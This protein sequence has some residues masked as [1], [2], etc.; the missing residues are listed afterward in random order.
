MS[1]SPVG[2]PRARRPRFSRFGL[3]L[4]AA[5]AGSLAL[6][7][8]M[9]T[10][11]AAF[12]ATIT[13]TTNTAT[14]GALSIRETSTVGGVTSTC[15]SYDATATCSTINKYGGTALP[16]NP[17]GSQTTTVTMANVGTTAAATAAL[18]GGTCV[19]TATAGAGAATPTTPNTTAG[20]LCSVLVLNVYAAATA[21][22]TPIY[23]GSP[24]AFTASIT[25][26]ALAT[27]ATQ[28]Y[29]FVISLPTSATSAVQ[30][31]TVSQ[32]MTW[33]YNA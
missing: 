32:P 13:N 18:Q 17:G 22:G 21:T 30:G 5:V 19:A 24:A 29:T 7:L 15:N 33:T 8:S 4:G 31:Q 6:A 9:G 12:T 26:G 20:N 2:S 1:T 11:L 23:T 27:A 3:T 10:S 16:I 28:S 14:S 25:L